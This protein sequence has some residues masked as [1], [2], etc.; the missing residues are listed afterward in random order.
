VLR[1]LDKVFFFR[2]GGGGSVELRRIGLRYMQR[3]VGIGRAERPPPKGI[4]R[5]ISCFWADFTTVTDIGH[6]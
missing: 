3:E 5:V 4:E 2:G 1:V 6:V